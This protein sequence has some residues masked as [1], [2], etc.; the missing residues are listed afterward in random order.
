MTQ[1]VIH[2]KRFQAVNLF[3]MALKNLRYYPPQSHMV[4]DSLERSYALLM[5]T[6]DQDGP[7]V[8]AV[9][10]RNLS[11]SACPLTD[12]EQEFPQIR[13]L[14]ET[15]EYWGIRRM[16]FE[17]DLEKEEWT[18]FLTHFK[19]TRDEIDAKG[20]PKNLLPLLTSP[21]I[22]IESP[23]LSTEAGPSIVN[24]KETPPMPPLAQSAQAEDSRKRIRKNAKR[25]QE[26]VIKLGKGKKDIFDDA[27]LLS[28]IPEVVTHWLLSGEKGP[29]Q[30]LME[31]LWGCLG[32]PIPEIQ[33]KAAQALVL[34]GNR[35]ASESRLDDFL[36]GALHLARWARS[37]T[38]PTPAVKG[39]CRLFRSISV[40][41]IQT[42]RFGECLPLL[43]T[44]HFLSARE[45]EQEVLSVFADEMLKAIAQDDILQILFAESTAHES[46][47]PNHA[48]RC[49]VLLGPHAGKWLLDRLLEAPERSQ[50]RRIMAVITEIGQPVLG[51]LQEKIAKGGP[52]FYLR[53]L[54][55]LLGKLGDETHL[56]MVVP[57]LDHKDIRVRRE[58]LN[59]L[60]N[61]GGPR[62][63]SL[64]LSVLSG[65]K[66][67]LKVSIVTMLGGLR[68]AE[69][70]SPLLKLL[71]NRPLIPSNQRIRLEEALC[72]ALGRI[73]D[74]KAL[75]A[76]KEILEPKGI[77]RVASYPE[78]VQ[79]AAKEA[80]E[81][82][83]KRGAPDER[84]GPPD[85][86]ASDA[87]P[88]I[89]TTPLPD[90]D[91]GAQRQID[92]FLQNQDTPGAISLLS[93]LIEKA[94]RAKHFQRAEALLEK[95]SEIDPMALNEI[96]K[97]GDIIEREKA[98][99]LDKDRV[100]SWSPLYDLLT[101]EE[102]HAFYF[103]LKE[104]FEESD[105][106][107]IQ[108]EKE[109][110]NLFFIEQG[111]LKVV[112]EKNGEEYLIKHLK[113]GDIAGA[114]SFFNVTVS[115]V[116]VITQTAV[117]LHVLS[118][119]D[120]N[121]CKKKAPVLEK[122]LR[123]FARE[124]DDIVQI[125]LNKFIERR[126]HPRFPAEGPVTVQPLQ[127]SG[128]PIGKAFKGR[129][130]NLSAGGLCFFIKIR[131][132]ETARS[133]LGRKINMRF[134]LSSKHPHA[135]LETTGT[136][137]AVHY[138]ISIDFSV[139]VRFDNPLDTAV[140]KEIDSSGQS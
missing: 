115:T 109:N 69:A 8:C 89:A 51:V 127:E 86:R 124:K 101:R 132:E 59:T 121:R 122:K 123:G 64:L 66:E 58:A 38:A 139:H 93:S 102:T 140:L 100:A 49:L 85:T 97:A 14:V 73:G 119:E 80:I 84:K 110:K 125:L 118:R 47:E 9:S 131:N 30:D 27:D 120:L 18:Q 19:R 23:Y 90:T 133:L 81:A 5:E 114:E 87:P 40:H 43:E 135:L 136:I 92:T 74:P 57:L 104:R 54:L 67:S 134:A 28:F 72:R 130:M 76:L 16:T 78:S 17:K 95:M 32:D 31:A 44:L 24:G 3:M 108:Q 82:I 61:I 96:Y 88:V 7:M 60:Y 79:E 94:A 116:S 21:H 126:G 83:E 15:M 41:L 10:N 75:P 13:S 77:K 138:Q 50:R 48:L 45:G 55:T 6:L 111:T 37:Q 33:D 42:H 68:H 12:K 106:V 117:K 113:A 65:A 1:S 56:D 137:V 129:L 20:G 35:L 2:R 39:T 4:V 34:I 63:R 107:L 91:A 105:V 62:R 46:R 99:L 25:V 70:L 71:K 103:A 53:N 52:W 26:G 112:F 98:A 29:V 128:N 11:I 36:P 22:H